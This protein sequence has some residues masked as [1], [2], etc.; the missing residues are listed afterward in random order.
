MEYSKS[1]KGE[2]LEVSLSGKFTFMDT[3]AYNDFLQESVEGMYKSVSID[4]SEVEFID[5]AALGLL[6]LTRDKCDQQKVDLYLKNPTGQVKQMF[7]ISRFSEL[8][9]IEVA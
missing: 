8:F 3:A 6:L 7:D 2:L 9:N 1:T 4:L 5:S